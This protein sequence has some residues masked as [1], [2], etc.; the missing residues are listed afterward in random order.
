[1][2]HVASATI[3]KAVNSEHWQGQQICIILHREIQ[4]CSSWAS[5]YWG[6]FSSFD[7]FENW[8]SFVS[9]LFKKMV[10]FIFWLFWKL[11]VLLP[12]IK[13]K[14]DAISAQTMQKETYTETKPCYIQNCILMQNGCEALLLLH[15]ILL[16]LSLAHHTA[17]VL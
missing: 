13:K 5:Q 4:S 8:E 17:C 3:K 1:M 10:V 7:D 12:F 9:W 11:G 6:E 15:C 14:N 2:S 16:L